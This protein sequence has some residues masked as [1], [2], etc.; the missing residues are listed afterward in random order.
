[1]ANLPSSFIITLDGIPIAKNINPD[2][3]QIHAEADHNNPAVFTFNDGLLES[4]GWYLGRFQIE[5]RSLL[6]KRVLWHKKGGD[7]REDLIQK[8]T[9]DNDGG[10]LVLKNGGTVLTVINGQVYGDL[11]QENP[12]TVGIKAA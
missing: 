10:E 2:E 9:I 8:T 4:D 12:A 3:E 5:D 1:M 7:V 6:P 11:M